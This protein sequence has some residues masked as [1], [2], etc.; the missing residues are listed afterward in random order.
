[1]PDL[2][3]GV[4][5]QAVEINGASLDEIRRTLLELGLGVV[6]DHTTVVA[7]EEPKPA[8]KPRASR[9]AKKAAAEEEASPAEEDTPKRARS[10]RARKATDDM[11]EAPKRSSRSRGKKKVEPEPEPADDDDE[12]PDDATIVK[13]LQDKKIRRLKDVVV[14]LVEKV[15]WK[16]EEDIVG[17]CIENQ[18]AIPAIEDAE[19]LEDR[20]AG[21]VEAML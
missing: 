6:A 8:K 21:M 17:F 9:A 2:K 10:T 19:N 4:I 16:E 13:A 18:S 11:D 7:P 12:G 3:I 1:M 15:G 20:I 5:A 14:Y